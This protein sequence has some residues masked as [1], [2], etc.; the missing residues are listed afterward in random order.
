MSAAPVLS[1]AQA[2]ES[3]VRHALRRLSAYLLQ[4]S[5][6]YTGWALIT[7]A[8]VA[9]FV[10]FPMLVGWSIQGAMDPDVPPEE[11]RWRFVALLAVAVARGALRFFSRLLVFTA[12]REIEYEIRNDLF[13]H[14]QRLPQS[15]YFNWR[16][17]DLMSR[18]VNDLNA[19]RLMLGPGL[20]SVVQTPVLFIGVLS[21]M[22]YLDPTLAILVLLPYPLFILSIT[23]FTEAD[24]RIWTLG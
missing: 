1:A 6:Y 15:F 11:L 4:N 23:V 12:A 20:L 22:F 24:L 5:L 8:Y 18:C 16:T 9:A 21:A 13:A 2:G 14:L 17:G 3:P 19:V 10:A 7:L